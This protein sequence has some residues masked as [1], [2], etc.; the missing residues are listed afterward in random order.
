MGFVEDFSYNKEE[1]IKDYKSL[2]GEIYTSV[3]E[4]A[5]FASREFWRCYPNIPIKG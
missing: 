5:K 1:L 3:A 2:V 4:A